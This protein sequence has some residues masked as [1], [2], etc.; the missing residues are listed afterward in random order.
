MTSAAKPTLKIKH[1]KY[2]A[3]YMIIFYNVLARN[4]RVH[5]IFQTAL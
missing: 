3:F 2:I 4:E 1:R 5:W